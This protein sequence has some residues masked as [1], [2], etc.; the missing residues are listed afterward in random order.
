M[1]RPVIV[2]AGNMLVATVGTALMGLTSW[3]V[4]LVFVWMGLAGM[5]VGMMRP[6][7]DMMVVAIVP[8][9]A[10]GKAFGFVGTGLSVGGA[11]APLDGQDTVAGDVV[12][13]LA[14]DAAVG[15]D[16]V[17]LTFGDKG[18]V[19]SGR[20]QCPRRAGLNALTTAHAA[21]R[22][23]RVVEIQHDA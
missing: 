10:T 16:R 5:A 21:R 15:A 13:E 8:S 2:V 6:A 1:R 23:H 20:H 4:V 17:D 14:A 11:I 19:A 7:R 12:G 18:V 3:S 9:H 22:S